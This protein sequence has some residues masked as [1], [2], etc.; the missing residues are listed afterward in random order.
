MQQRTFTNVL[1]AELYR[2][3]DVRELDR[4]TI[5]SHGVPGFTLMRRA[6][7]AAFDALLAHWPKVSQLTVLCGTG[8][9]GGDGYVLA[10]IA[11][12]F[13]LAVTVLQLGD[14]EKI[15]GDA[16]LAR[17]GALQEGVE[18]KAFDPA[19][20]LSAGLIVDAA[21]GTGLSGDVRG[22]YRQAIDWVNQQT[23]PVLAVDIPS[24]LCSDTGRRLG[25][26]IDADLTVTF[27][28]VKRG[29]LTGDG[30]NCCGDLLYAD[31][32]VPP[33]IFKQRPAA[34]ARIDLTQALTALPARQPCDH[35]GR[36][37]HVLVAGGDWGMAG[38][39]L[40][41]AMAA[42]RLGAGLTACATRAEHIAA[43]IA[44]CPEVMAS[45]V[46]SGQALQPLADRASVIVIGPGLGQQAWGQQLLQVAL[47][48]GLPLVLD[49]DALNLL[50]A[51]ILHLPTGS[52]QHILT[53]HPAEAARLLA[54]TTAQVQA[55]R[56][57]A[58]TALQRH[59][60]G[61]VVLK[62]A[63]TV[64]A[65]PGEA[66]ALCDA[67]NPGMG[68]GGMGDV[69]SGVLGALLAQGLTPWQAATLG[70]ALHAHAGD[71]AAADSGQR[72]L[73]AS[74]LIPYLRE[75]INTVP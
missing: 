56:F 68:S 3:E 72:G 32:A 18:V 38:A 19:T 14:A 65:G 45:A 60:G 46:A 48:S 37:G 43:I 50:A 42:A 10:S 66:L 17:T 61:V 23:L 25:V 53:P 47:A 29:L 69:L 7:Q 15:S 1:P 11:R 16:L 49:A 31:L 27:I 62:G 74:D 41:A 9:N 8:N 20:T 58:A 4:L 44:R 35:K 33:A 67:G 28:G 2:A 22:V 34:V 6:A 30:P 64:V 73:L 52:D 63:G 36:F 26:A 13:G 54:M 12:R 5:E 70:V 57:A 75:L 59:Y 21:L 40:M 24:G 51:G 39:P 71:L 55:D